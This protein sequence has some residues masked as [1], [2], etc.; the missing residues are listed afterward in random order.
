M[1]FW[2]I[3]RFRILRTIHNYS[4]LWKKKKNIWPF[5]HRRRFEYFE[6]KD[7]EGVC[8][9]APPTLGLL[10]IWLKMSNTFNVCIIFKKVNFSAETASNYQIS[11]LFNSNLWT[12]MS[13]L[14]EDTNSG[15][16]SFL[17]TSRW[18]EDGFVKSCMWVC[19]KG[20]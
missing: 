17:A 2:C 13:L 15:C 19:Q 20:H 4:I 1:Q 8:R 12:R 7:H 14:I 16:I 6:K 3:S 10:I 11:F 5:G 9:T 18:T